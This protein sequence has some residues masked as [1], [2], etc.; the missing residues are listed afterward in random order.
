MSVL[1]ISDLS[2]QYG[3]LVALRGVSLTVEEGE[4]ACIVGPNGAGKS[5]TL[6]AISGV[7]S[8]VTGQITFEGR[9]ERIVSANRHYHLFEARYC[10]QSL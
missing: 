5:T 2:V 7:L 4:I 10:C 9:P 1:Q 8:S 6:N 3:R